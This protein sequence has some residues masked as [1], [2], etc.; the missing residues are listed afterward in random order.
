MMLMV[1][2]RYEGKARLRFWPFL[3]KNCPV[4]SDQ[5]SLLHTEDSRLRAQQSFSH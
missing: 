1:T 3:I 4:V 2:G 5:T